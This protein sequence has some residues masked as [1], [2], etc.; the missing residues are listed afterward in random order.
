MNPPILY[1]AAFAGGGLAG[2]SA[3]ILLAEAG[4]RT[5]LIEKEQYPFHKVCGEFISAAGMLFLEKLGL[6]VTQ[7]QLPFIRRLS[8]SDT[9]GRNYFFRLQ[10]GGYGI[11]RY[12]LDEQLYCQAKAKGVTIYTGERVQQI[13]FTEEQFL[14]QTPQRQIQAR[15]AIGSFGKRSNLDIRWGRQF[16]MQK[17]DKLN[18]YIA[19]KYHVRY[20]QADDLIS[21]HNFP[22]GYCGISRIEEDRC[23]LCYLTTAHNLAVAGNSI[24][25][26]EQT[27]LSQNPQLKQ[28]FNTAVFLYEQPLVISQIS[29]H[30]KEQVWQHLLMAGDAAGLIT[31]LCGNG[32]SMALHAGKLVFEAASLFLDKRITRRQMEQLYVQ[33]W[34][35]HFSNRLRTG[36]L[37]QKMFGGR[38]STTLFLQCMQALP[39]AANYL[40]RSTQGNTF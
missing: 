22:G 24:P 23:C 38:R 37:V 9:G 33:R 28:I 29:F 15:L 34:R 4:Y 32:M 40:I 5:V 7:L 14:L 10:A 36:R 2:L 12:L 19:V 39:A 30:E 21:L 1:D 26:M 25:V 8:I 11:S 27:I 17:P 16:T 35:Q 31:P 18:H 3:A 20:P 6:P 13:S